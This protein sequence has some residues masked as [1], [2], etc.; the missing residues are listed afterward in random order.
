M[1]LIVKTCGNPDMGEPA[2]LIHAPGFSE[3]VN[4]MADASRKLR[5]YVDHFGLGGGNLKRADLVDG[6]SVVASISYNGKVW[7]AGG[8]RPG[9][10]PL[11]D[12]YA[13]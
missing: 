7:P 3:P 6:R 2:R 9:T 12:P 8:W 1:K 4:D 11:F 10:A 13:V 5:A